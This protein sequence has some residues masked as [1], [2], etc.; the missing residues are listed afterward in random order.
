MRPACWRT[1][2]AVGAGAVR[3]TSG[4]PLLEWLTNFLALNGKTLA[5]KVLEE[6]E[7]F[8]MSPKTLRR[9]AQEDVKVIKD[10]K[11]GGPKCTWEL[12]DGLKELMGVDADGYYVPDGREEIDGE[13]VDETI[14]R[15]LGE[16][17]DDE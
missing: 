13:S 9:A 8:G 4:P 1:A 10:P 6:S 17:E 5:S 12:P 2:R 15:I 14:D 16:A 11:G 3:P 7:H